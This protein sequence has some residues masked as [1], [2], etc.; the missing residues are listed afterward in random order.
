MNALRVLVTSWAGRAFLDRDGVAERRAGHRLRR[1]DRH[2]VLPAADEAY[3]TALSFM[4]G[5]MLTGLLPP[6]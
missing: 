1:H 3:G 6:S 4:A 5:T 2:P